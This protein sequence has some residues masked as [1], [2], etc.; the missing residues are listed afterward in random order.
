MLEVNFKKVSSHGHQCVI[1]D[2]F[3]YLALAG[4]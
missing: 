3:M 1:F 4:Y 2:L